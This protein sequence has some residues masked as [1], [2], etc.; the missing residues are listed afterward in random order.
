MR[1]ERPERENLSGIEEKRKGIIFTSKGML[2]VGLGGRRGW[3]CR[4]KGKR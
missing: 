3:G 2:R 4:P 1:R